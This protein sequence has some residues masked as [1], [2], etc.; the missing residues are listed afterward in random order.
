VGRLEGLAERDLARAPP[1]RAEHASAPLEPDRRLRRRLRAQAARARA[2]ARAACR[3]LKAGRAARTRLLLRRPPLGHER[4]GLAIH[5]DRRRLR[6]RLAELHT[7]A[8]NPT[9]KHCSRLVERVARELAQAGWRLGA[10]ITDNGSEFRSGA[11]ASTLKRLGIE[12]RRIRA[13]RP[14]S[15]GHVERLQQT[16]LEECWRPAFARSLVPKLTALAKDLEHYLGYYNFDRAHTGRLT[17]G[18]IPGEIV[19]GARKMRASR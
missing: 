17:K 3:G 15:N 5:R 7:S 13:G 19:Y 10:A 2:R 8:R 4:D 9:A 12:Q 16:I 11:F 18:R 6:L 14:T 1:T